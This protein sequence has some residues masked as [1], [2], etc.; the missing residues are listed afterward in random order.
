[1]KFAN[2]RRIF[3]GEFYPR[4]FGGRFRRRRPYFFC[5]EA[6]HAAAP[7]LPEPP[8][9]GFMT[10]TGMSR[11]SRKGHFPAT[12]ISHYACSAL[13]EAGSRQGLPGE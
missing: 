13:A 10:T 8:K 12:E 7:G 6:L 2:S 5:P 1:M 4:I 9:G 11:S 3:S